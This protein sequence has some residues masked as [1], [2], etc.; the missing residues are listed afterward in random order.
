MALCLSTHPD[1]QCSVYH[2]YMLAINSVSSNAR[3]VCVF[4][5]S[6]V[7]HD[8]KTL[9]EIPHIS[10][11]R[12]RLFTSPFAQNPFPLM[13]C[14]VVCRQR[15]KEFLHVCVQTVQTIHVTWKAVYT[16][17]PDIYIYIYI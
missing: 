4:L 5:R 3:G 11:H 13:L 6:T 2:V 10:D 1:E 8:G 16:D 15:E 7:V 14:P 9:V 12:V 17:V